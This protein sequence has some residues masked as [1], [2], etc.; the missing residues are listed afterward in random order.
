LG[1]SPT[2]DE[3]GFPELAVSLVEIDE[4]LLATIWP[5]GILLMGVIAGKSACRELDE[6]GWVVS[7][8]PAE[9]YEF[10]SRLVGCWFFLGGHKG[11]EDCDGENDPTEHF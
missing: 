5:V 9:P 3:L 6:S 8:S 11:L 7:G 4:D 2:G 10:G 1:E